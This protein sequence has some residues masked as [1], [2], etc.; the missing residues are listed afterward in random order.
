MKRRSTARRS[1]CR[2]NAKTS[3]G[4]ITCTRK[5]SAERSRSSQIKIYT[6][7]ICK[8]NAVKQAGSL[9][10]RIRCCEIGQEVGTARTYALVLAD[11]TQV[12]FGN[13]FCVPL[14]C[15]FA[16]QCF[17]DF[18]SCSKTLATQSCRQWHTVKRLRN[19]PNVAG[20]RNESNS[21]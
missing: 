12:R 14:A 13:E 11:A 3:R 10:T 2:H 4:V 17:L 6:S 19:S 5:I 18:V 20:N 7:T 9:G 1:F 15:V 21:A 16:R 8:P